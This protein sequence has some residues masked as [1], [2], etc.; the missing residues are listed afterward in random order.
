MVRTS[1]THPL[2]IA[3]IEPGPGLGRIGHIGL[4]R[5]ASLHFDDMQVTIGT[6]ARMWGRAE[7]RW[8]TGSR[9]TCSGSP[10]ASAA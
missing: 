9:V 7:Q 2:Q 3:T 4:L 5:L 10:G 6:V 1:I 8:R